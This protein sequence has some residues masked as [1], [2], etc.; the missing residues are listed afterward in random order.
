MRF[1]ALML[2]CAVALPAGAASD[3]ASPGSLAIGVTT[4]DVVDAS[5]NRTL[6]T[7]VWYPARTPGRDARMRGGRRP[8]VLVVHGH[9]GSRTNYTYLT[10]HLASRGYLV[11][12]PDL[13]RF[14]AT[15]DGV[16][17]ADPPQ[18][19]VFLHALL[20]DRTGSLA[21]IARHV[22]G[23]TTGLVGHSLGGAAALQAARAE[24]AFGA[25][26]ALAP[27]AGRDAGL[28]FAGLRPARAVLAM[29]GSADTT[30]SFDVLTKPFFDALPP[31]AFLVRI[32]GGT[33][34]GFT[35]VDSS[36]TPQALAA[37]ETIVER[38]ATAF[39]DR[40]LRDRRRPAARWLRDTD[41]GMVEV[42][43]R[44]G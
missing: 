36:L 20:H 9:C 38:Y 1:A 22:R 34:S 35:D 39:F 40:Y 27:V 30:I 25:V 15:R 26:V 44:T 23:R 2:V 11:A 17:V 29:G 4:V 21:A 31:P 12:A 41:D 6:V 5:R 8:L 19:L 42:T 37:Q 28:A 18:D 10:T 16:D 24:S 13:P 14:C 43:A 32:T 3:P 33:H 7:E